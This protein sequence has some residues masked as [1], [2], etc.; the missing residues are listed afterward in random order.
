MW[1]IG[2]IVIKSLIKKSDAQVDRVNTFHILQT[3]RKRLSTSRVCMEVPT[4]K[5]SKFL[6]KNNKFLNSEN[7]V[8]FLDPKLLNNSA[9]RFILRWNL[10]NKT[11]IFPFWV[12]ICMGST[13]NTQYFKILSKPLPFLIQNC[14][15][16]VQSDLLYGGICWTKLDKIVILPY[17]PSG[18]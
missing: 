12:R 15:I 17:F 3:I 1:A 16:K 5:I 18:R 13:L 11:F 7:V 4:L 14:W 2:R 8:L 10:L 6:K 9:T